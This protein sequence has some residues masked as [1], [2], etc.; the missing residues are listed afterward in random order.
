MFCFT[1]PGQ[2][3]GQSSDVLIGFQRSGYSSFVSYIIQIDRVDM[4]YLFKIFEQTNDERTTYQK[5]IY[6]KTNERTKIKKREIVLSEKSIY[7]LD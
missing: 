7:Y 3:K 4:I 5:M 6:E 1:P 2:T